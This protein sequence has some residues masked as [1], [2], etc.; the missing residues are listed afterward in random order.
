MS[1]TSEI[2]DPK[3]PV[4]DFF[5]RYENKIGVKECLSYFQST[6]PIRPLSFN[7]LV[8]RPFVVHSL[9]GTSVDYLIRYSA[10][11][12]KLIFNETVAHQGWSLGSVGSMNDFW[13]DLFL[14]ERV[15]D[16]Y[17]I[18]K[19]YMDGREAPN[20]EAVHSAIALSLLEKVYRSHSLPN[21]FMNSPEDKDTQILLNEYIEQM[22]G[23][24][25]L[26]DISACMKTFISAL[27]DPNGE[28]F[29]G[30]IVV[31]NRGLGNSGLVGGAD[32]DCVIEY[33]K[34]LI[35]TEI[36][37]MVKPLVIEHIRQVI[38]YALLYDKEKDPFQFSD[39][40]FY[41]SRSGS[42]RF[43]PMDSILEKCFHDLASVD[44]ARKEFVKKLGN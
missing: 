20:I 43:L 14:D 40:G 28:L 25:L 7:I 33:N 1:L 13:D 24:A 9:I 29:D 17:E 23:T 10:M 36:K 31:F 30:R 41:H 34:T 39:V 37:S 18:G 19:M 12:N 32:F 42:F 44:H 6:K 4:R 16:L 35:L 3:S 27:K 11:G 15:T 2:K 21:L 26:E 38:G 5:S 8:A 22:G